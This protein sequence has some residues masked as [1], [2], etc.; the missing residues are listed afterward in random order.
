[1]EKVNV[2][3]PFAKEIAQYM[4]AALMAGD[5]LTKLESSEKDFEISGRG[6]IVKKKVSLIARKMSTF[7]QDI[8]RCVPIK[9]ILKNSASSNLNHVQVHS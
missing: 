7:T 3:S 6:D 9:H 5:Y 4:Q 2:N 8:H 1:M